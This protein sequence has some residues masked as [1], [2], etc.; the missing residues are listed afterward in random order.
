MSKLISKCLTHIYIEVWSLARWWPAHLFIQTL[1]PHTIHAQSFL[2]TDALRDEPYEVQPFDQ[3]YI[4]KNYNY[5]EVFSLLT[6]L[7]GKMYVSHKAQSSP[8]TIH[9]L[10]VE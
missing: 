8:F 1:C 10:K 2:H 4:L 7:I 5:I 9:V 6:G 3:A